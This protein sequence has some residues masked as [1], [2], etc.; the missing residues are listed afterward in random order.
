MV[1]A[2][3][4]GASVLLPL[5]RPADEAFEKV[6]ERPFWGRWL[7]RGEPLSIASQLDGTRVVSIGANG[8]ALVQPLG[9]AQEKRVDLDALAEV[10]SPISDKLQAGDFILGLTFRP[11]GP[12]LEVLRGASAALTRV[13]VDQGVRFGFNP[14]EDRYRI[15]GF[16][17]A[18]GMVS[19]TS[20]NMVVR[21]LQL[22]PRFFRSAENGG[23]DPKRTLTG[24]VGMFRILKQR[25]QL[26]GVASYLRIV[27]LI[28]LNLFL[29]NL[30]PIP[31]TDGGQLLILGIEVVIRRPLPLG[32]R[33]LLQYIGLLVVVA[34]MLYVLGLDLTRLL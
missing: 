21:T 4:G 5:T 15:A 1:M 18:F 17:D 6:A 3:S 9:D 2:T 12:A 11:E 19:A 34:V 27:A 16:G 26:F 8:T 25:V 30:L 31:I 7:F 29:V 13:V 24:P 28:G 32:L 20:W 14:D 22:L 10:G 33:N 23:V